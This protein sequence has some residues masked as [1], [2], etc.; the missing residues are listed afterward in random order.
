MHPISVL[1][2]A[3][4][5]L[6]LS[7]C[8]LAPVPLQN[9]NTRQQVQTLRRNQSL[10]HIPRPDIKEYPSPNHNERPENTRIS[11][12]VLHHTAMAGDAVAVARFFA[13][14]KAGASSHYIVDRDGSIIQPVADHLRSWHAG[15]SE[16][17]GVANVNDFS[18]GIE[19]CNLGDSLEPYSDAQ[20][21]GIIRL[22]AWL[23]KTYQV[24]LSG[25]TRHRD[26]ALPSGRKIDTSNNFSMERVIKGVQ[27]LL[28]GSYTPPPLTQPASPAPNVPI[29]HTVVVEQGQNSLQ[30]LAD[31]HL[32]NI[33]RWIEIQALN[34][35]L[36]TIKPGVKV[37]IP[38]STELFE[39]LTR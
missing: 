23:V 7:A 9:M 32:D 31:I 22:V 26:V 8:V 21:D 30:D 20:Y 35:G 5:L 39:R 3:L 29:F 1:L 15:R 16:F 33:N 6:S 37:K 17:N 4:A 24:P 34:P 10:N 11:A 38:T 27:A 12:I 2:S 28:S 19:I 18:I 25:I 14:P 13:N 36:V